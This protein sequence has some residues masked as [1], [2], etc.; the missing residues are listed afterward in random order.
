[1]V[2]SR[3]KLVRKIDR[4][5]VADAIR[6]AGHQTTGEIRVSFSTL[7]LGNVQEAAE[8]A[9]GRMGMTAAKHRNGVLLFVVP[10][11]R[12]FVVVGDAGIHDKVGQQFWHD[13]A[14]VV[15]NHFRDGKFTDGL[16]SAVGVVGE[17]LALHY[18]AEDGAQD[19]ADA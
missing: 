10:A 12:R 13:V 8:R 3:G 6:R 1:M 17:Q 19:D 9:F 2:M 7:F 14:Q 11:R 15:S 5:R 4:D 16:V 18:P